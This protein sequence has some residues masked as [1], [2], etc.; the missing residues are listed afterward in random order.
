MHVS[1]LLLLLLLMMLL[2]V[3][4]FLLLLF[5]FL[6]YSFLLKKSVLV[7][8]KPTYKFVSAHNPSPYPTSKQH[9]SSQRLPTTMKPPKV[10][11]SERLGTKSLESLPNMRGLGAKRVGGLS[12]RNMTV[13][14]G[15]PPSSHTV[16]TTR[17]SNS[18]TVILGGEISRELEMG[19]AQ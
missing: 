8:A 14:K 4:L 19:G 12:L 13:S 2:L 7:W 18:P 6:F 9:F 15:R 1:F 10:H 11:R 5:L 16:G 3:L 17:E